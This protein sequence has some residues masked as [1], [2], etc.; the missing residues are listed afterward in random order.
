MDRLRHQ[1]FA[2][3]TLAID[4]HRR[5]RIGGIDNQVKHPLHR[6]GCAQQAMKPVL[7]LQF[8]PEG[9]YLGFLLHQIRNIRDGFN[10]TGDIAVAS[11]K[12]T[13][14]ITCSPSAFNLLYAMASLSA[15]DGVGGQ[16][17]VT[18]FTRN[19]EIVS[20]GG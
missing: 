19:L 6:L 20:A 3:P 12:D 9:F 16:A 5:I 14:P 7:G 18:G 4:N 17:E 2:G 13:L 1:I 8:P 15:S 10:G 11:L